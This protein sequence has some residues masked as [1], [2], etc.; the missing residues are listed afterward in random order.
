MNSLIQE[1]RKHIRCDTARIS[2]ICGKMYLII[3]FN[4][5]TKDDTGNQ[6]VNE[7]NERVDFDYIRESVVA[8]G[9][10]EEELINSAKEYGELS[11]MTWEQYFGK[12][13]SNKK[14]RK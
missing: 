8:S 6:I 13:K 2:K 3:G 1:C 11:N 10:T 12:C 4:R 14:R 7:D 5:N 9:D